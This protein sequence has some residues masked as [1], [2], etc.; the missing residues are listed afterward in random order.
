[1]QTSETLPHRLAL[2]L[3]RQLKLE[4]EPAFEPLVPLSDL[5]LDSLGMLAFIASLEREFDVSISDRDYEELD[6]FGD[7]VA[8]IERLTRG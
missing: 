2:I 3:V 1:L 4:A 6:T 7:A 5:G 8:L